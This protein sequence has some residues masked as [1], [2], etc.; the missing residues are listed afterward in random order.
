MMAAARPATYSARER[1][2]GFLETSGAASAASARAGI[3]EPFYL[4]QH[5][6]GGLPAFGLRSCLCPLCA[7]IRWLATPLELPG[8][9]GMTLGAPHAV[10]VRTARREAGGERRRNAPAQCAPHRA[11]PPPPPPPMPASFRS[12]SSR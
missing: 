10:E 2:P 12:N 1:L 5:R 6:V 9:T 3:G 7:G 8:V 11:C 4:D